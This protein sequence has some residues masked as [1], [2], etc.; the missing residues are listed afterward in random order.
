[1]QIV[2]VYAYASHAAPNQSPP[3]LPPSSPA[4]TARTPTLARP[5]GEPSPSR[6]IKRRRHAG[7]PANHTTQ[8]ARF[9]R[10][11]ARRA[12][13]APSQPRR[14]PLHAHS[15]AARAQRRGTRTVPRSWPVLPSAAGTAAGTRSTPKV[16][17]A[18]KK[19]VLFRDAMRTDARNARTQRTQRTHQRDHAQPARPDA[20]ERPRPLIG[21]RKRRR[22]RAR[23][24]YAARP[25]FLQS[26]SAQTHTMPPSDSDTDF[27]DEAQEWA[28]VD[29]PDW[30][31]P[32]AGR[33]S[34]TSASSEETDEVVTPSVQGPRG[35][36]LF[37]RR[38][39]EGGVGGAGAEEFVAIEELLP[40]PH[41]C[42]KGERCAKLRRRGRWRRRVLGGE[43]EVLFDV[44]DP[45]KFDPAAHA[46]VER[47]VGDNFDF[48]HADDDHFDAY[49]SARAPVVAAHPAT[50]HRAPAHFDDRR[51]RAP[52]AAAR[53]A[54]A[55]AHARH[56]SHTSP[57][58]PH[59]HP[60]P[61]T[62]PRPSAAAAAAVPETALHERAQSDVWRD[63]EA[64]RALP[65]VWAGPAPDA[66]P[67]YAASPD[68]LEAV[69]GSVARA[70][71]TPLVAATATAATFDAATSATATAAT[72]DAATSATTATATA[73]PRSRALPPRRP[74][75]TPA[76]HILAAPTPTATVPA[77]HPAH[78]ATNPAALPPRSAS[79]GPAATSTSTTT[80]PATTTPT[81]PRPHRPSLPSLHEHENPA[82]S[83]Q[84]YLRGAPH[85]SPSTS[86]AAQPAPSSAPS[87][88]PR[89]RPLFRL[90]RRAATAG[91]PGL[92]GIAETETETPDMEPEPRHYRLVGPL[93]TPYA[94]AGPGAPVR[95]TPLDV[96]EWQV[97]SAVGAGG[98]AGTS[99]AS[100]TAAPGPAPP[101]S[102]RK[103]RPQPSSPWRRL[104]R[105]SSTIVGATSV[106]AHVGAPVAV[107]LAPLS[108]V[109]AD[110]DD[111]VA[112]FDLV[113][114]P[115]PRGNGSGGSGGSGSGSGSYS[116]SGGSA[117]SGCAV[118]SSVA[119]AA[120]RFLVS[121]PALR[122]DWMRAIVCAQA[123]ARESGEGMKGEGGV[124]RG[125]RWGEGERGMGDKERREWE[126][127][128]EWEREMRRRGFV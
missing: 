94:H 10:P 2:L 120:H 68:A 17:D 53:P 66:R 61:H 111:D 64:S 50:A 22:R 30:A 11:V 74:T 45:V 95:G 59:P 125:V 116:S 18:R 23:A 118:G 52:V 78:Y 106:A 82:P 57:P 87:T 69:G 117:S 115:V 98:G 5:C 88:K 121:S 21:P 44:L 1:M 73:R 43:G 42:A 86:S 49:A 39:G 107:A 63:I 127:A 93:L 60:H 46:D 122:A 51:A 76:H 15:A 79:V 75:S 128:R 54:P 35:P 110:A 119:V 109:R 124:W 102:P 8:P 55:P 96:R 77:H 38:G 71:A 34:Q 84:G 31:P 33:Q 99:G 91:T 32:P 104:R 114:L 24:S 83:I 108:P 92:A 25:P 20:P 28:G 113:P 85:P 14:A 56:P 105:S 97:V 100:G 65:G 112:A 3:R 123:A 7:P 36:H 27:E 90:P 62:H 4:L 58:H 103:P 37:L 48:D 41:R 9:T 72:F 67:R 26:G 126:R 19:R 101:P 81:P 29:A 13:Q 47:V 89:R 40:P 70:T 12:P 6:P 80:T 16:S